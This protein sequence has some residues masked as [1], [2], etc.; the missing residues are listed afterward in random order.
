MSSLTRQNS[1]D[2]SGKEKSFVPVRTPCFNC[3]HDCAEGAAPGSLLSRD[4]VKKSDRLVK[5]QGRH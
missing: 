2:S 3:Q 4:S 5:M 1:V